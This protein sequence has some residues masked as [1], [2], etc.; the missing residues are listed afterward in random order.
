MAT[1]KKIQTGLSYRIPPRQKRV[2]PD[3]GKKITVPGEAVDTRDLYRAYQNGALLERREPLN[4]DINLNEM[5]E[6]QFDLIDVEQYQRME[7]W[8]RLRVRQDLNDLT[9]ALKAKLEQA[10]LAY[11]QAEAPAAAAAYQDD[12]PPPPPLDVDP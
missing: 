6:D 8:D 5:L 7:P 4:L 12:T 10:K 1:K 11:R 9:Q 3:P 2:K